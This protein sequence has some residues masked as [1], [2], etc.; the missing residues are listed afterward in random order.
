MVSVR[1]FSRSTGTTTKLA[2]PFTCKLWLTNSRRS[3]DNRQKQA[4]RRPC[5]RCLEFRTSPE[6]DGYAARAPIKPRGICVIKSR[7]RRTCEQSLA[8]TSIMILSGKR[9][10]EVGRKEFH[11]FRTFDGS[12]ARSTLSFASDRSIPEE[13]SPL[14]NSA[15][16]KARPR[17]LEP[18]RTILFWKRLPQ[19][20]CST[21]NSLKI[22]TAVC[23]EK[24]MN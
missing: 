7:S 20:R 24:Q 4:A 1:I 22:R 21:L 14:G 13:S 5:S 11:S 17:V 8:D 9:P 18:K 10:R 12:V 15:S 23:L 6:Q 2:G 3:F 16:C 19:Q